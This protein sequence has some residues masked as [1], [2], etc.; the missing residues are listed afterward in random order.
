MSGSQTMRR[1]KPKR[2]EGDGKK[3]GGPS[4][5][6]SQPWLRFSP[7]HTAPPSRGPLTSGPQA[8]RAPGPPRV[9]TQ[10]VKRLRAG[11]GRLVTESDLDTWSQPLSEPLHP[12]PT[13]AN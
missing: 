10:R 11:A 3:E 6:G 5:R 7:Y 4:P 8:R 12:A 9:W 1:R 13:A 2:R